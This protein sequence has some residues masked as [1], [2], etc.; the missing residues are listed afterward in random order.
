[1][2]SKQEI[3]AWFDEGIKQK[4]THLIVVCDS[5]DHSDYPVY[6]EIGQ[7]AKSITD[8]YNAKSMQRVIEV[9]NLSMDKQFQLDERTAYNILPFNPPVNTNTE[10]I[11]KKIISELK[12]CLSTGRIV[13]NEESKNDFNTVIISP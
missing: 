13:E 6:V 9:Y 3:S 5:Y 8:E 11:G 12:D 2:T 10:D 4:A 1:M 7:N